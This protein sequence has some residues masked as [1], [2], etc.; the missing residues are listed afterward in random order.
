MD[1]AWIYGKEPGNIFATIVEGRPNGM[2]SF[3]G[4]LTTQQL[5]QLVAYVRSLS[6]EIS[7][8]AAASRSDHLFMKKSE[9]STAALAPT[10]R[11][12]SPPPQ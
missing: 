11:S 3:R 10:Q 1:S 9:Q 12:A 5:W 4:H 6:G 2:P 7:K 8:D